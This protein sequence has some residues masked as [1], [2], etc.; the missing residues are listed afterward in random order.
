[1]IEVGYPV[2]LNSEQIKSNFTP[3]AIRLK[4]APVVVW[5]LE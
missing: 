2:T 5:I 1:M 3:L 4:N